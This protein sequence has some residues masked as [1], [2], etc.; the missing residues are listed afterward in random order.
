MGIPKKALKESQFKF[1]TEGSA[2][3]SH[4]IFRVTFREDDVDKDAFYKK[5]DPSRHYP[6][7]LA[8][9]SVAVSVFKRLFQGKNS[10]E[11]RLVFNDEEELIGTLS[12][13]ITGFKSLN[14]FSD[15]VP[16]DPAAKERV[17]PSTKTLIDKN[18]MAVLFGRYF[19][20]DDDPH[21]QNIGFAG[22][23][24]ADIDFDMFLYWFTIWMKEPRPI[25]GVPK[26]RITLTVADWERF[27]NQKDAKPYH[28]P[29]YAHPGQ[30]T[31]P[32]VMRGQEAVINR[33]APKAYPEPRQFQLLANS[34]EAQEQKLAIAL[35]IL[36]TYQPEVLRARLLALFD[37]MALNYTSLGPELSAKYQQE[38][39][40]LCNPDTNTKPFVDF[41]MTVFQEHYDSL[42]RV[43]VFYMGCTNNGYGVP[44]PAMSVALYSKPSYYQ[45]IAEWVRVQNATLYRTEDEAVQYNLDELQQR[46][47]QV[48]R[49]A[50]A[51]NFKSLLQRSF[52]LIKTVLKEVS[53]ELKNASQVAEVQ[54][55]PPASKDTSDDSLVWAWELFGAMPE[56][57]K[58]K[59]EHLIAVDTNSALRDALWLLFDFAQEFHA[60]VKA[61]YDKGCIDLQV[62]DNSR[63]VEAIE[64]LYKKY[65]ESV[66]TNLGVT[67]TS[68]QEFTRIS[69]NLKQ[70]AMQADFKRHLR[71]DDELMKEMATGVIAEKLL[72]HTDEEVI[73]QFN[74]ALF[75]WAKMTTPSE[76]TRLI[77]EVID[78]RYRNGER[79]D[80]VIAYLA[81]SAGES[82]D[83]RLAYILSS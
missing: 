42:Y 80:K 16:T 34:P 13:A 2:D 59:I 47:H 26:K 51:P 65:D 45:N 41:M 60:L 27:P 12:I 29:T 52:S 38:F 6:E 33:V 74:D 1:K 50:F 14:V 83:N 25:I 49:D 39:P 76:L 22:D 67:T 35:K 8:M 24:A 31:L 71:N 56:L 30:E 54:Q 4:Q 43:V 63:F 7:L 44:L 21:P 3:G 77:T 68:A 57:S 66:C 19:G 36:V 64:V 23:C 70:F 32:A 20:D 5:I 69:Y 78:K 28:W 61:Y 9:I 10:A 62:V 37:N 81:A 40:L 72:P 17:I 58:I 75:L 82:G 55:L 73:A 11:E 48:W 15:P 46:Y 18:M 53:T 79:R